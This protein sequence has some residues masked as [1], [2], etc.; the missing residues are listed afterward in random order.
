MSHCGAKTRSGA[1]CR[2]AAMANG[3]CRLHGGATPAGI[4]SANFR[5]GR[6]SKDLP[7]RLA[8]RFT[9]AQADPELLSLRAEIALIDA[10]TNELLAGIGSDSVRAAQVWPEIMAGFEQRRKL[11][12]SEIRR[13]KEMQQ[14]VTAEQAAVLIA[15]LTDAVRKC[16][17]DPGTLAA[18]ASEFSRLTMQT[19]AQSGNHEQRRQPE[20]IPEVS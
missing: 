20:P 11:V 18:I 13:L 4:A 9:E 2:G 15:A 1:P 10:R 8:A 16:V 5:H 3:R 17:H 14:M 12:G 19:P 6:Y 7:A